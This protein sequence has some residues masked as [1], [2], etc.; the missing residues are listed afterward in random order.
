[1]LHILKYNLNFILINEKYFIWVENKLIKKIMNLLLAHY[2][3][4]ISKVLLLHAQLLDSF[5]F[6]FTGHKIQVVKLEQVKH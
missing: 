3:S 2:G 1:M 5:L 6:E 4:D